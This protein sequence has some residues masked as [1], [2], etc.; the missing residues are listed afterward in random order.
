MGGRCGVRYNIYFNRV[1]YSGAG[2]SSPYSTSV[3]CDLLVSR[4]M[5]NTVILGTGIIGVSIAYYLSDHQ[6]GSTVHLVEPSP[7]LFASASGFAAGFLAK[8]WFSS[9]VAALGELSFAEHK[10][11]AKRKGG[12]EKWGYTSS[13]SFSHAAVPPMVGAS[14]GDDWLRDGT[15]RSGAATEV[16]AFASQ[17]PS[18]LRRADG[19]HLE[20]I[21]EE[22]STAQV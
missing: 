21:G 2:P 22:G 18:W 14:R 7:E 16:A 5:A 9:D 1:S 8:D 20:V 11:L 15:S 3:S 19:D 17:A 4:A 13:I 12:R 6:P 10:K